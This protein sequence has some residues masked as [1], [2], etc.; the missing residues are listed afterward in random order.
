MLKFRARVTLDRTIAAIA[1]RSAGVTWHKDSE[2]LALVLKT[3]GYALTARP[4]THQPETLPERVLIA[5]E[6]GSPMGGRFGTP[7][8]RA[9]VRC[10]FDTRAYL[11]RT[12]TK[13]ILT[14]TPRIGSRLSRHREHQSAR[15]RR[16]HPGRA[17]GSRLW[18]YPEVRD[19]HSC[20]LRHLLRGALD[21]LQR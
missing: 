19:N 1:K 13:G 11:S 20:L 8:S 16:R 4:E 21:L 17:L 3:G 9:S 12:N 15:R 5:R 7:Y 14:K 10:V 18:D 6:D 2:G